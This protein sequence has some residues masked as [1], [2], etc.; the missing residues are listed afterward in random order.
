M[1]KINGMTSTALTFFS[2]FVS[3]QKGI[4]NKIV[5]SSYVNNVSCLTIAVS[6]YKVI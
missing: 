4:E 3:R 5:L 2:L 6:N 1:L